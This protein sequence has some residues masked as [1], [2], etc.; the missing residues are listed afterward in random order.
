MTQDE[1]PLQ[2]IDLRSRVTR[3]EDAKEKMN[4]MEAYWQ[5]GVIALE[6]YGRWAF[7]EFTDE[8]D[9]KA[10]LRQVIESHQRE[11]WA[12]LRRAIAGSVSRN[13]RYPE[14]DI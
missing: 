4:P 5:P 7:A 6:H 11:Y 3:G 8:F 13:C 10:G 14:T 9:T 12:G 2:V 1:D